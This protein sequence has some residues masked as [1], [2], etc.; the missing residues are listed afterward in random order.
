MTYL[1]KKLS[2]QKH[3]G[4]VSCNLTV[5]KLNDPLSGFR[6]PFNI[7]VHTDAKE[8]T[9]TP[10]ETLNRGFC[11]DFVQQPCSTTNG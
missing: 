6:A 11:L 7:Y 10:A 3:D 8:G 2:C 4:C 9:G 5:L 1:L